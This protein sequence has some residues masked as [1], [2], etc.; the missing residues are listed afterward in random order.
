LQ[1]LLNENSAQ[2]LEELTEALNGKLTVSD[3]V[4]TIGKIKKEGKWI[5][6]ESSKLATQ[7]CLTICISLLITKRS[8]F[9]DNWR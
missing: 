7:N 4:H 9:S 1:A 5:P 2:M 8:S 6:F 3:C